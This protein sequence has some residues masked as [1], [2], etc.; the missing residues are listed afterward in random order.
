MEVES[1]IMRLA[2]KVALISGAANG[3]GADDARLFA[4]E[5]A[6]VV[7]GDILENQGKQLASEIGESGGRALFVR[8]D[9]TSE[10]DWVTAAEAAVSTFGKLDILVNNAGISS[11]SVDDPNSLENWDRIMNINS[12]GVFL[13]T[14]HCIPHMLTNG[15]GSIVNMSSIMG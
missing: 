1:V 6:H 15:G 12:T 4:A 14:K 10:D 5:G 9:V 13:G 3:M 7:V 11:R 8:L 2:G